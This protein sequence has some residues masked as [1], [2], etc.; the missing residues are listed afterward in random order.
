MSTSPRGQLMTPQI[1]DSGSPLSLDDLKTAEHRLNFRL[2]D[3]Y[4][5]FLLSNNGGKATPAWFRCGK[6]PGDVAEIARF[7]SLLEV[8]IETHDLRQEL[9][10]DDFIAIGLSSETDR[11]LL[12]TASERPG[13]VF[14]NSCSEDADPNT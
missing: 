2:P 10:S 11:L 1:T 12:S 6:G 5:T 13:A 9:C 7:F 8:E 4:R 3:D 14:L